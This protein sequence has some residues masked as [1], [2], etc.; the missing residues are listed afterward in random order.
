MYQMGKF[1]SQTVPDY[2]FT[3]S[4]YSFMSRNTQKNPI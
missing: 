4:D 3:L 1:D 2:D